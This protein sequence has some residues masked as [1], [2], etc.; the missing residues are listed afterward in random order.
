MYRVGIVS[1]PPPPPVVGWHTYFRLV[2][3][4]RAG[5][6]TSQQPFI[7]T[8]LSFERPKK[9]KK[10][11]EVFSVTDAPAAY[12]H[13]HTHKKTPRR[14]RVEAA[15]CI[16]SRLRGVLGR[17]RATEEQWRRLQA[18]KHDTWTDMMAQCAVTI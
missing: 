1:P 6:G 11:I 18:R 8:Q 7:N 17:R 14:A 13:T 2:L 4:Y 9:M 10:S 3:S 12:I 16:Q 5:V 15:T